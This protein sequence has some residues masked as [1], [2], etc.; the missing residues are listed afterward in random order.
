MRLSASEMSGTP[1]YS[2]TDV[3]TVSILGSTGSVGKN[4]VDLLL[5]NRDRYQAQA[6][7]ANSNAAALAAQAISLDATLAVVADET[8]YPEL[9]A[10][11]SGTGIEFATGPEAVLAAAKLPADWIM[12]AIVGAAGLR[13]TLAAL[14][15]GTILALANKECLVC[16]GSAFMSR[17]ASCGTTI[18]PVDSEHCAI[19]QALDNP[20]R[21]GL[22]TITLTASGGPFR[23]W[24]LEKIADVRPEDALRHPNWDMG[25]KITIDSATMMNK[26]LELIEAHH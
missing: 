8:A 21:G 25:A 14:E 2:N 12:A 20:A 6:L 10:A 7:V 1:F 23:T 9:K 18:L 24:S 16:A 19:F 22:E 4:T 5:A 26:G 13:P 3:R 17:A 11:L 15:Q